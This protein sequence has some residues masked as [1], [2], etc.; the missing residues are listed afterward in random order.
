MSQPQDG[1]V[2]RR[3]DRDARGV[4]SSRARRERTASRLPAA[5]GERRPL[6]AALAVL[7]IVGGALLA[8]L[9]A[10]RADH[11]VEMLAAARTVAAGAVITEDDLVS[12]PVS[13]TLDTLIPASQAEQLVGQTA[14][15]EIAEGQLFDTSQ[16]L[17]SPLP[18][19]GTQVVGVSLEIGRFPAGG[20]AAGDV[21]DVV[22]TG[23]GAVTVRH[24][25]VLTA[26]STSGSDNDWTSGCV[27]SLIVDEADAAALAQAGA[28]GSIAVVLTATDQPI[29]ES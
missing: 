4:S 18:G 11:R 6:L 13:S 3:R 12:T 17:N 9:L 5:P 19:D 8:G 16:L 24:A 10:T 2:L 29:G 25:Q 27:L 22:D 23:S 1:R 7:L 20:L 14:R 15:T 28:G 26:V 21:V